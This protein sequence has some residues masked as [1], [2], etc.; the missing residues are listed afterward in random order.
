MKTMKQ[1]QE[2]MLAKCP[3]DG[4]PKP[5]AHFGGAVQL[6]YS[7]EEWNALLKWELRMLASGLIIATLIVFWIIR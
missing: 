4:W 1:M 3:E 5:F 6:A 7:E 2:E